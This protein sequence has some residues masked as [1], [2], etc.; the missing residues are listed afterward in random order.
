MK[1]TVGTTKRSMEAMPSAWFRR[2]VFHDCDGG[3]RFLAMY[4]ATVDWDAWIPSFRSSPWIR[5]APHGVLVRLISRIRSLISLGIP[6]LPWA[7]RDFNRQKALK[8]HLCQRI[9]VSGR[10]METEPRRSGHSRCSQTNKNRSTID[11]RTR[12]GALRCKMLSGCRR[13][14]ISTTSRDRGLNSEPRNQR[15]DFAV[16]TMGWAHGTIY[17]EM[18]T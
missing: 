12:P 3:L 6:G 2:K 14:R 1:V 15:T 9:T 7:R 11:H 10:T 13:A 5:G 17:H 16:S 4:L 18:A 8:P